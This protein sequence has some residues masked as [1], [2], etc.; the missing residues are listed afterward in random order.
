MHVGDGVLHHPTITPHFSPQSC[1]H[2]I[3]V[4]ADDTDIPACIKLKQQHPTLTLSF[5][6]K[7][8]IMVSILQQEVDKSM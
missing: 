1:Q 7:E 2:E 8:F 5:W 4:I 3:H 6:N